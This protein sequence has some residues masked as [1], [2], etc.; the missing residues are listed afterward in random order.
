MNVKENDWISVEYEGL[1]SDGEVFDSSKGK[2][3]LK[4]KVGAGMVIPGFDDGVV[5]M[6]VGDEKTIDISAEL[7]YGPKNTE[8]AKIP[9]ELLNGITNLEEGKEI[10]VMSGVGPLSIFIS[11]IEETTIDA[12]LNHPLAGKDLRF[13]V[14]L[15]E[16]L[17]EEEAAKMEE[18]M[19]AHSCGGQCSSCHEGCGEEHDDEC[20][21]EDDECDC[22]DC[23]DEDEE[24]KE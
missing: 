19:Q 14:K 13:K 23:K 2:D 3:P 6:N 8:V 7:A 16:I 10:T 11:K 21:C 4:F 1:L 17:S 22:D 9:K 18:E 12:I 20:D 15:L 5:G 24:K